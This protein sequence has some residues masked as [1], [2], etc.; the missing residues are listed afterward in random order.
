MRGPALEVPELTPPRTL[1]QKPIAISDLFEASIKNSP[2]EDPDRARSPRL[3]LMC[4]SP[5]ATVADEQICSPCGHLVLCNGCARAASEAKAA[6]APLLCPL[7]HT[8]IQGVTVVYP[9][10]TCCICLDAAA[11]TVILPCGHLS[12]CYGCAPQLWKEKRQCPMCQGRIV[13]FRRQ[14]P[15]YSDGVPPV[16]PV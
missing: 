5:L 6:G 3:C 15:I 8:P 7:C 10:E 13:S 4:S 12:T 11:D 1:P 9:S 16:H 14:F 2:I